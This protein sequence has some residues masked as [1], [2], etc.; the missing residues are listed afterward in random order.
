MMSPPVKSP[1]RRLRIT[2]WVGLFIGK[3]AEHVVTGN[4]TKIL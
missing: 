4:Q 1:T 2:F 3:T